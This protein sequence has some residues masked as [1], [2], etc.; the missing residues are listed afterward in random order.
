M[1]ATI[2]RLFIYPKD[3]QALT[4]KS[5]RTSLDMLHDIKDALAKPKKGQ[6]TIE[7]FAKWQGVPPETIRNALRP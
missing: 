7:E 2:T 6:V 3:V 1:G 4:G 5:Y